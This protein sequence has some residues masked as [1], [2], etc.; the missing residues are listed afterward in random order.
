[1]FQG[2][3]SSEDR[4]GGGRNVSKNTSHPYIYRDKKL[5]V[6]YHIM[7]RFWCLFVPNH[8]AHNPFNSHIVRTVDLAYRLA[9]VKSI[10]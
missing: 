5:S 10:V 4:K 8:L 9:F 6:P 7:L 1:M 2:S 3:L